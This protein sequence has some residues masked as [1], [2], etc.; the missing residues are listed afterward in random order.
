MKSNNEILD[1]FGRLVIE[2]VFDENLK[3]FKQILKG[4]T[5][6]GQGQKYSEIFKKMNK[7]D[8]KIFELFFNE[9]LKINIFSFLSIFEDYENFKVTYEDNNQVTNLVEA[10]EM[11]KAELIIENG[12]IEK[13]SKEKISLFDD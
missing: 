2:N 9:T 1:K 6:W 5:K 7:E 4:T 8:K 11:L 13:Y 3:H 10:S 12:W